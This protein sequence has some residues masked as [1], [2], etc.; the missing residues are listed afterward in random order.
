MRMLRV[1]GLT[2]IAAMA[3][4]PAIAQPMVRRASATI[5][6]VQHE[7]LKRF[8]AAMKQ[9]VRIEICP[10]SQPCRI[11]RMEG[12]VTLGTIESF[13]TPTSFLA[14]LEPRFQVM[15]AI[16][17]CDSVDPL[18]KVLGDAGFRE[19]IMSLAEGKGVTAAPQ[20][21]HHR[22]F[23]PADPDPGQFLG[24][25]DPGVRHAPAGRADEAA[26]CGARVDGFRRGARA[27]EWHHRRAARRPAQVNQIDR[28]G[29]PTWEPSPS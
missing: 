2:V 11:P 4:A 16:G 15:D 18:V 24:Q 22:A 3:A 8:E 28:Q 5:N 13:I 23:A 1:L 26:G 19:R 25:E 10:A 12:G 20:Q 21:I 9:R 14:S 7:W 6:D 29:D 27:A 17:V